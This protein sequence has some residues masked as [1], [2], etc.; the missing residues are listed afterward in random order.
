MQRY[1]AE[2]NELINFIKNQKINGVVFFSGD[3]HH[4]E[5]IKIENPNFYPLYD[6]TLS[7][8]TAGISKVNGEE[9]SSIY[10]VKGTLVE[11][12]NFGKIS[13]SGPKEN[14]T[15]K[16]KKKKNSLTLQ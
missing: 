5:I 15:M 10:R 3:R 13:I 1:S 11:E 8:Y 2:Y 6:V 7:S 12:N 4:S 14:R 9:K 16:I